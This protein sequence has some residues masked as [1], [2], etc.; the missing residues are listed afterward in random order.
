MRLKGSPEEIW[1]YINFLYNWK[2]LLNEELDKQTESALKRKDKLLSETRS[3][4]AQVIADEIEEEIQHL[5]IERR[6]LKTDLSETI[7]KLHRF[8]LYLE[9]IGIVK[10]DLNRSSKEDGTSIVFRGIEFKSIHAFEPTDDNIARMERGHAPVGKDG[11]YVNLHHSLQTEDG[12]I[13]E[14][15]GSQHKKWHR[16]IHI[17][18]NTIPSGINRNAFSILKSDFWRYRVNLIKSGEK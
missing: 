2:E 16:A 1:A 13:W 3:R 14:I 5:Q 7:K 17:N 4:A 12:P 18:P 8:L 10:P 6:E 11:L 15:Q 9:S